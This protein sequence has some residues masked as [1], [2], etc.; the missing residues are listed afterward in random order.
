MRWM[1]SVRDFDE[2]RK[3][4]KPF[5]E[6]LPVHRFRGDGFVVGHNPAHLV[7][8]AVPPEQATDFPGVTVRSTVW[9]GLDRAAAAEWE[10]HYIAGGRWHCRYAD[11]WLRR[12]FN[13]LKT[14]YSV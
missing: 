3:K 5:A 11:D 14:V 9:T 8:V 2:I 10:R 1:L 4:F 13:A 7:P 6:V 12:P